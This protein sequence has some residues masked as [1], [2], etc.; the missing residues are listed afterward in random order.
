MLRCPF[1]VRFFIYLCFLSLR[2]YGF[3]IASI[4]FPFPRIIRFYFGVAP[5]KFIQQELFHAHFWGLWHQCLH[6]AKKSCIS[7]FVFPIPHL[8]IQY[9][10]EIDLFSINMPCF[11]FFRA[12]EVAESGRYRQFCMSGTFAYPNYI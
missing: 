3:S 2:W 7:Q 11:F 10:S 1:G 4:L 8:R 5:L 9:F 6:Q 12:A